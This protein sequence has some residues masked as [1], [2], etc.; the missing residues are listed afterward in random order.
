MNAV[1][2]PADFARIA[3]QPVMT[4]TVP[5]MDVESRGVLAWHDDMK[6]QAKAAGA[7]CY[8]ATYDHACTL[9]TVEAYASPREGAHTVE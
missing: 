6:A 8:T 7:V 4:R 5:L 1:P 9:L 3:A 2:S